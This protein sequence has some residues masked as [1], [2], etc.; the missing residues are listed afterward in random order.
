MRL[1]TG[2]I[3]FSVLVLTVIMAVKTENYLVDTH[4]II[5]W[6]PTTKKVVALTFDDGPLDKVTPEIL[7]ILREKNVKATFFVLG[8]QAVRFPTLVQ[9]EFMEGHEI[10]SHSFNHSNLTRLPPAEIKH[11]LEKSEEAIAK[12]AATPTLFRPPGGNYNAFVLEAAKDR[13]YLVI[14]WSVDTNDWRSHSPGKIA[15]TVIRNVRPG[16]IILLHDG[17]YPSSTPEALEYIIDSL[18]RRGY[19]FVTISDLLAE[20]EETAQ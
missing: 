19:E 16:S 8:E 13:G 20:Y 3:F 11:Q 18:T 1:K 6:V 14:L 15:D 17:V 5:R 4:P 7:G 2:G 10:G 12:Y 9:Q